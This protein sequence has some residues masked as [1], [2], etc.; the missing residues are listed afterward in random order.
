MNCHSHNLAI[1]IFKALSETSLLTLLDISHNEVTE[2]AMHE[3]APVIVNNKS[4]KYLNLSAYNLVKDSI[5]LVAD[6]LS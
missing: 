5:K 3:I 6:S 2:V 4:L 1:S